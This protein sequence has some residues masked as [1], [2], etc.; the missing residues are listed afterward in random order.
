MIQ[1]AKWILCPHRY[2]PMGKAEASPEFRKEF[3]LARAPKSATLQ[4]CGLGFFDAKIN[5]QSVTERLLTPPFTAYDKRVYF[6]EYDVSALLKAGKNEIHVQLGGGWYCTAIRD[7]WQFEAAPWKGP[8]QMIASLIA[9]GETV[10]STGSDWQARESKMIE[11]ELRGGEIC[12]A[13][14]EQ[15]EWM[16]AVVHRGAGGRLMKYDGPG[17]VIEK[18]L[19]PA[20]VTV[21]EDGAI[22]DFGENLAGNCEFTVTGARGDHM[23]AQYGERLDGRG[24]LDTEN[25]ATF[26]WEHRFQT[27]EYICAGE[28]EETWHGL[29]TYHGFRYVKITGA[30]KVVSVR[31][32]V[33]HT[34]LP[35]KG[36][37][38]CDSE[39]LNAI[40]DAVLRSTKTNYHHM[41][42][43]CPHR[44][45]NGWTGDA[46]LSC[47]QALFNLD[48]APAYRKWL[49][50][51]EDAQRP[52]GELPGILPTGGWGF[53]WGNGVS[54]D[55]ACI[56]IPWQTYMATGDVR[57]LTEHYGL[58]DRYID[59]MASVAE[60]GISTIGLGDWCPPKEAKP[61]PT[62][63]LLTGISIH[64]YEMM[65]KIAEIT[66]HSGTKFARLAEETRAAF[67]R[68]FDGRV[69]DSQTY[70]SMLLFFNLTDDRE[71][72]AKRLVH[73]VRQA[74][75]HILTG[76][77]GAKFLLQALTDAGEVET[78]YEIAAQKEYPGWYHMLSNG[79][80]T[81]WEDWAGENS[82][83][84]HMFS[85]ISA[86]FYRGI[87]GITIL[88]PGYRRVRIAPSIPS[89][90]RFFRAWHDAP[91]G[92][93]T[94][95]WKDGKLTV[96]APA[97]MEVELDAAVPAELKRI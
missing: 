78:A 84:H 31:A 93:L 72:V 30:A 26:C 57:F 38:E 91:M 37:F 33:F 79:S 17:V 74:N 13:T 46:H 85:P 36:G 70:L 44:E 3:E 40:Q 61:F 16:Q 49:N 76:I 19:E 1:N 62:E 97:G 86:W 77:F 50:D 90:I 68:E 8:M 21:V 55:C 53:V 25:I 52:T 45:K 96:T 34:E 94:V 92:R 75:G 28:G 89:E 39:V 69:P 23:I 87:A 58:M 48:M 60:N 95:E 71:G 56:V 59:Y 29:F 12:D 41:P 80:G 51:F 88:E 54:W 35:Q 82:L 2:G 7:A 14:F 15:G 32:R 47:E 10:T 27:D 9:D 81:L 73:E 20:S 4:I 18:V 63:A 11:S 67:H 24:G 22:Y 42:T 64:L 66:G 65:V 83:N 6:E 43:D 5:G